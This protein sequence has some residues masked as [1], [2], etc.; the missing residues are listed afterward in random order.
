MGRIDNESTL[1]QVIDFRPTS[2]KPPPEPTIIQV[3]YI[4]ASPGLNMLIIIYG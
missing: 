2:D 3:T 4:Y 1:V